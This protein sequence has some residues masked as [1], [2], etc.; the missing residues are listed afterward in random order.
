MSSILTNASA[1]V[2]LQTL[3]NVQGN[4]IE[5]QDRISTG[6]K[7]RSSADNPAFFLVA[8]TLRGDVRAF[9]AIN[10]NLTI[11]AGAANVATASINFIS[12][13]LGLITDAIVNAEAGTQDALQATIDDI[14]LEVEGVLNAA[15]FNG[16]NLL[17]DDT[18][19]SFTESFSRDANGVITVNTYTVNAQDLDDTADAGF[20]AA[21]DAF[22]NDTAT[23]TALRNE[24]LDTGNGFLGI[25]Q[26]IDVVGLTTGGADATKAALVVIDAL[27]TRVNDVASEIGGLE[28]TVTSR[29]EYLTLLTDSLEQGVSALVEADLDEESTKLQAFQVQEQL[30]IQ[31]LG[32][33]NQNPQ[34]ILSLFR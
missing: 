3:R 19:R 23:S 24:V 14:V 10:D 34:N 22:A 21:Y 12:D 31:A 1:Q 8:Q 28:R 11:A 17:A 20:I 29:Q 27:T 13:Q 6:L 26:N 16:V 15:S 18:A 30:A 4:L 5:T 25:L 9:D 32:I 33:A 2:A 7:V